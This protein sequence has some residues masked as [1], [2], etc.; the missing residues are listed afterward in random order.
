[1]QVG[2]SITMKER[3]NQIGYVIVVE[4]EGTLVYLL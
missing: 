4:I 2:A 1:L 3:L